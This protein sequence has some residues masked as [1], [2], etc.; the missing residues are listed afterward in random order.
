MDGFCGASNLMRTCIQFTQLYCTRPPCG[1]TGRPVQRCADGSPIRP[2]QLPTSLPGYLIRLKPQLTL[3]GQVVASATQRVIMGSDL[4]AEGG[5]TQLY[6]PTQW[7]I[8]SDD[9]NV[10]GQATAIG[11]SAGGI[12]AQ[13]LNT[14][15]DRL[16]QTQ[17][18]LQSGNTASIAT[19][20]GEQV[21]GDLLTATIWSWFAAADSH[22][23]LSQNQAGMVESPGL[24]YGLFHAVAQARYSW[25]VIRSVSFPGVNMDIGHIRNLTWA[26]DN[27]KTKWIGYN[28][29]RGQYMSALEHAIPERFFN[30][31]AQC[32]LEGS[33]NPVAGL[34]AC[35]QGVS[36]VK[37]LGLAAQAGQKIYTITRAVYANNPGI[38]GSVLSAHSIETQQAVQNALDVG[39]EVTIHEAPITQG[40]WTGAGYT[41]IDPET[42]AGANGVRCQRPTGS[43]PTQPTPTG[44]GLAFCPQPGN[45][46]RWP[47]HSAL[48]SPAPSIT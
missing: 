1:A 42:G 44:S 9:S 30:N 6:D 18:T 32:N 8:T 34:P 31:P 43:R 38:V 40:G 11:I 48:N 15:K 20:S 3:D 10:A 12:S 47:D 4:S 28:R 5:F 21:S 14:L 29:L 25:G 35:P 24:S 46:P 45:L 22:N 36:A 39:L 13:Q 37:A 19:L 2:E 26:K 27:D 7:D 23:R 17:S 33:T 16:Q 41:T